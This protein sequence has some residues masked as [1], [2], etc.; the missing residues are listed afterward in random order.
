MSAPEP[1]TLKTPPARL[2]LPAC[3]TAPM[4][5][6]SHGLGSAAPAVTVT[7]TGAEM[8]VPPRL[9]VATAVSVYVAAATPGPVERIRSRRH[10]RDL[11]GAL[12]EVHPLDLP[13]A[14]GGCRRHRDHGGRGE[15]GAVGGAREGHGRRTFGFPR[16]L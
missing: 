4:S 5:F 8:V 9:S 3:P 14:V 11:D 15:R 12:V 1:L 7:K 6:S 2:A 13:I 10:R 16:E